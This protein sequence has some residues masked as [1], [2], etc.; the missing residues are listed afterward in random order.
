MKAGKPGS[1]FRNLVAA[2]PSQGNGK[3]LRQIELDLPR[4]FPQHAWLQSPQGQCAMREVLAAFSLHD[5]A[6]GYCQGMNYVAGL[7]L[8]ATDREPE[9]AFWLLAALVGRILLPHTYSPS[10]AGC[11]VEMRTLGDL[12]GDKM[13]HLHRHLAA[14]ACDMSLLSMD[15]FLTLYALSLPP[16]VTVRVWDALFN[17]GAKVLFRVGLALLQVH[18]R[19]LL[20]HDNAGEVLHTLKDGAQRIWGADVLL[21]VAFGRVGSL[22]LARMAKIRHKQQGAVEAQMRERER[23]RRLAELR[24]EAAAKS[25]PASPQ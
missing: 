22:P 16:E 10:L 5:P 12:V 21:S 17:E 15:W 2:A 7:L 23:A 1:Y 6:L 14:M 11:Q 13:P 18:E 25:P 3:I 9:S 20:G 19:A 4:T 8:A 24:D